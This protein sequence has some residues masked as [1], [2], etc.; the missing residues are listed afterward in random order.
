MN[1]APLS[2]DVEAFHA[3]SDFALH[4]PGADSSP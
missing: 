3:L 2:P 4:D 1:N